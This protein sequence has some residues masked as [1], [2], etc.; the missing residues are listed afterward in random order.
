MSY[1]MTLVPIYHVPHASMRIGTK[2]A[3]SS[4]R[5]ATVLTS[6]KAGTA[7]TAASGTSTATSTSGSV[8][9]SASQ[10]ATAVAAGTSAF[11]A[12]AL[13]VAAT[14][15]GVLAVG[16][17]VSVIVQDRE[18][19]KK[20]LM[21]IPTV[22]TSRERLIDALFA[23]DKKGECDIFENENTKT[24]TAKYE[25]QDF[26]FTMNSETGCYDLTI[27]N[28]GNCEQMIDQIN[29]LQDEYRKAVNGIIIARLYE[30]VKSYGWTVES[31][32]IDQNETRTISLCVG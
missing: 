4:I 28:A 6:T 1:S 11:A 18:M 24:I 14:I 17:A 25:L 2:M 8:L 30:K 31:D 32:T 23:Y 29:A 7:V 13:P 16:L 20:S 19:K 15:L 26:I 22:F 21:Q 12:I 5:R 3:A 10:S 9:A 27:K